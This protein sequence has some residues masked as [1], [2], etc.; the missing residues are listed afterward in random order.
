M[1]E[2]RTYYY[3][4]G[5][6]EGDAENIINNVENTNPNA[7]VEEIRTD[8]DNNPNLQDAF[9]DFDNYI[10]YLDERQDLI[11]SG[12]LDPEWW[13]L[14]REENIVG[15]RGDTFEG[16]A[17]E[18]GGTYTP[19]LDFS[20]VASEALGDGTISDIQGGFENAAFGGQNFDDYMSDTGQGNYQAMGDRESE[21][22][23]K[24]STKPMEFTDEKGNEFTWNGSSYVKTYYSDTSAGLGD[25]FKV[26]VGIG[27][28]IV[29]GPAIGPALGLSGSAAAA[30]GAAITNIATQ[31]IMT[32]SVDPKQ[33]LVSAALAYGGAELGKAMEAATKS[34]GVLA[35]VN[36][37]VNT[38]VETVSGG[39][40]IAEAAIKAGGIS[41]LTQIVVNGE[42]DLKQAAL[43]AALAGGAQALTEFR[44]SL[45]EFDF[46]S[47]EQ[48]DTTFEE[49][50]AEL[51]AE[52]LVEITPTGEYKDVPDSVQDTLD[53][54]DKDYGGFEEPP[55]SL[56]ADSELFNGD[57]ELM[58]PPE[59]DDLVYRDSGAFIDSEG[60][61]VDNV[62]YSLEK[63]SYVDAITGETVTLQT[64]DGVYDLDG[65]LYAY[66]EDGQW[67]RG[68]GTLID[69]P[70]VVDELVNIS[71]ESG[72]AGE[73]EN[74]KAPEGLMDGSTEF[75]DTESGAV[76]EAE[77][78]QIFDDINNTPKDLGPAQYSGTIKSLD[79]DYDVY[80]NP[81]TNKTYLVSK[82]DPTQVQQITQEQLEQM[83]QSQTES[84]VEGAMPDVETT[85]PGGG[86]VTESTG[87]TPGGGPAGGADQ[88][89]G[90]PGDD[91]GINLGGTATG[92][93][94]TE[95]EST[96]STTQQ[97]DQQQSVAEDK[98]DPD[99]VLDA[100]GDVETDT[101]EDPGNTSGGLLT[102]GGGST[103]G[104]SESGESGGPAGGGGT[105]EGDQTGGG[106][107]GGDSGQNEGAG[108]GG[109]GAGTGAGAGDDGG[110]GGGEG[111]GE[112]EGTGGGEGDGSGGEGGAGG[113]STPGSGGMLGGEGKFSPFYS[114]ISYGPL[115]IPALIQQQ[116]VDTLPAQKVYESMS[117]TKGLFGDLI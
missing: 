56:E 58:G 66:Q 18:D 2:E 102:F 65:N 104:G 112:G 75:I 20:G 19:N 86:G 117:I 73:I 61:S 60:N 5:S 69:D 3:T 6:Y 41:A 84:V 10:A 116:Q 1:A 26:A 83:T 98:E 100:D 57:P 94:A 47:D 64:D 68:D 53:K 51:E 29:V 24:Y 14:S 9:G 70:R 81:E 101:T 30:A 36:N 111:G 17:A 38:F 97:E 11:D 43:A 71:Q 92:G 76:Y 91:L 96:E 27:L 89:S 4:P 113:G 31:A 33:A 95:Q 110:T 46:A 74:L 49:I 34:G 79:G 44:A 78:N 109:D 107:E 50:D 32:G 35:D 23:N 99:Q 21:L 59:G 54:S 62:T 40:T 55:E 42:V 48:W 87:G 13:T 15:E 12:D 115:D 108:G 106:G 85:D 28:G 90:V 7:T 93:A 37:S 16:M 77:G 103:S 105:G 39:S 8:W 88:T 25:Y 22:F 80:Y 52:G 63:D 45:E 114:G 67:F 72:V 82:S